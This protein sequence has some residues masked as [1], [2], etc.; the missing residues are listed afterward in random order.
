MRIP[1]FTSPKSTILFSILCL[2]FFSVIGS[3]FA[4]QSQPSDQSEGHEPEKLYTKA[5]EQEEKM[6]AQYVG[7]SMN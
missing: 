1:L 2:C 4:L 7:D 3:I 5:R 6:A